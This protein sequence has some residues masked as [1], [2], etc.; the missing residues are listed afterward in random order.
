[1]RDAVVALWVCRQPVYDNKRGVAARYNKPAGF[2][3]P[4][5]HRL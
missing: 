3:S 4:S 1:M 5:C 2:K